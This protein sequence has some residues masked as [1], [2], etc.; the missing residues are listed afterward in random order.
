MHPT[1]K[2]RASEWGC[3]RR[4]LRLDLNG[5]LDVLHG[6]RYRRSVQLVFPLHP[7]LISVAD[8]QARTPRHTRISTV[9]QT[10]SESRGKWITE[11]KSAGFPPEIRREPST[12][13]DAASSSEQD[14]HTLLKHSKRTSSHRQHLTEPSTKETVE[15]Q[16][17]DSVGAQHLSAIDD[18]RSVIDD[19]V[20][21]I[22][23][24]PVC[25]S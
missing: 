2:G 19:N 21:V 14:R 4:K 13:K 3:R 20:S 18:N 25:Y 5:P 7:G 11:W 10:H 8:A 6:Y 1:K 16:F 23:D 12:C 22:R 9:G 17:E 15:R 24:K